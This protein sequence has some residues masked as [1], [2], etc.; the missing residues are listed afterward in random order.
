MIKLKLTK[1]SI[2]KQIKESGLPEKGKRLILG[3]TDTKG[4][5]C[6]VMPSGSKAFYL[7]YRTK[8]G[9]ERRPKIGD[10][11][12]I[13]TEKARII[14][15]DW[16]FEVKQGNDPSLER[17][18]DRKNATFKT[19][20]KEYIKT[21]AKKKKR[22]S[23]VIEDQRNLDNHILPK[24]GTKK[25]TAINK[26]D[27]RK[28]HNAMSDTPYAAN[29]V[30][31]LL[32]KM[33]NLAEEWDYRPQNT[34]P[35][36]TL[37]GIKYTEDGRERY[38]DQTELQRLSKVL[39]KVEIEKVEMP[40]VISAIRLLVFTGCR[41][42]EILSLKWDYVDFDKKC[43]NLP[44]SKTGKKTIYLTAPAL[45]VLSNIKRKEKNPYVITGHKIG[46]HLVNIQKPWA[47][48]R[49][50]AELD[51][52]RI[53]DLR[54]TFASHAIGA[55][56]SLSMIGALLGH[57]QIQTTERYAHL[58]DDP[59]RKAADTIGAVLNTAMNKPSKK[60]NVVKLKG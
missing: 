30:F 54:H 12:D 17:Q 48:I 59:L 50:K 4:F 47:R 57:K 2:E 36:G 52:V 7:Y 37:K 49:K 11:G 14:A 32:A 22:A 21:H 43:I 41:R 26:Q 58:A 46:K 27:I 5:Q 44:D 35:C 28:L 31:A 6:R 29:R 56:S 38:L 10:Y 53:H 39:K 1:T 25:I 16:T 55:G 15:E 45:E 34:N 51:D 19:F 3:D 60:D 23:S 20:S 13:T 18:D 9:T 33:F 8:D 40:S 24:F 42:N